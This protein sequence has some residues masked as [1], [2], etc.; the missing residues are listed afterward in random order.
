MHVEK[1]ETEGKRIM[2]ENKVDQ[3]SSINAG[4]KV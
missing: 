4:N 2:P 1:S 3:A